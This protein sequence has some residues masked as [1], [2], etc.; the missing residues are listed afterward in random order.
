MNTAPDMTRG[1]RPA[2]PL[3]WKDLVAP[4]Q[5]P[6]VGRSAWQVVNTLVPYSVR[7]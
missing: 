7:T 2:N 6:T 3:A 4:Y 1:E 5:T